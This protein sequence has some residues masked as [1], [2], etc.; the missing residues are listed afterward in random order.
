MRAT[1][2]LARLLR[3]R[4]PRLFDYLYQLRSKHK[5]QEQ[6]R[7]L[8]P[9]VHISGRF[10]GERHYLAVVLPLAWHP[11]NRNALIVLDLQADPAPLKSFTLHRPHEKQENKRICARVS[12]VVGRIALDTA[13]REE[14]VS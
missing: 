12:R 5:V 1:I 10:A 4:Q 6:V 2:A 3:E 13:W 11:R 7:L 9:L 8:Q 14:V